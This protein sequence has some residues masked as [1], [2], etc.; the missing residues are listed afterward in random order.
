MEDIE[1]KLKDAIDKMED[2]ERLLGS[3]Y[4]STIRIVLNE[5]KTTIEELRDENQAYKDKLLE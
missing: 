5:A 3:Q 2:V 4:E 1:Y